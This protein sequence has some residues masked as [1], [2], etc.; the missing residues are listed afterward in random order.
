MRV[1]GM[2]NM[3][4]L[5]T[6]LREQRRLLERRGGVNAHWLEDTRLLVRAVFD[7]RSDLAETHGGPWEQG[8]PHETDLSPE[9]LHEDFYGDALDRLIRALNRTDE[10]CLWKN[11]VVLLTLLGILFLFLLAGGSDLYYVLFL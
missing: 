4:I 8:F 6:R 10:L 1:A 9:H 2:T 7:Q 11:P 5:I 3:K